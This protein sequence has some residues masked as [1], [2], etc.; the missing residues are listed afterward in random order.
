MSLPS[1]LYGI[2]SQPSILPLLY[3]GLL[4]LYKLIVLVLLTTFTYN[5]PYSIYELRPDKNYN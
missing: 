5:L 2:T 4:S 1:K 3:L